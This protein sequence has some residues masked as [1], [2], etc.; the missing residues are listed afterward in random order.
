MS[1][2]MKMKEMEATQPPKSDMVIAL[3]MQHELYEWHR[4]YT[5]LIMIE[6]SPYDIGKYLIRSNNEN[7][8]RAT[9]LVNKMRKRI[10][11][12]EEENK[13]LLEELTILN[14]QRKI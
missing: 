5:N 7:I 1:K 10:T 14:E 13:R 8:I 3:E 6:L 9:D 2:N 12:L 11:S 4:F